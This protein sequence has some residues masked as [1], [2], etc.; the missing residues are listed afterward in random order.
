MH[1]KIEE[2]FPLAKAFLRQHPDLDVDSAIELL[3]KEIKELRA[4]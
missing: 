1:K 2:K 4:R 3:D